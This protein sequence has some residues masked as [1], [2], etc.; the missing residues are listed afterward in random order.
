M[1]PKLIRA[2]LGLSED[3][4]D[5]EVLAAAAALKAAQDEAAG[6]D[7]PVD[8]D[9]PVEEPEGDDDEGEDDDKPAAEATDEG[10][11]KVDA[12]VWNDTVAAA[13]EGRAARKEQLTERRE[14]I[15][16]KAVSDGKIAP[17]SKDA[18]RTKLKSEPAT[19]EAELESLAAGLLPVEET[20]VEAGSDSSNDA[21]DPGLF[22]ELQAS[23]G[24]QQLPG[25]IVK[26]A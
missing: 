9:K 24:G 15:L 26:E 7:K 5:E 11:V 23:A 10:V 1:D 19:A 22:P 12:K 17:A 3:A 16:A 2:S 4:T 6:D 25:T 8:D 20:K 21:Y 13:S 14:S 18:W